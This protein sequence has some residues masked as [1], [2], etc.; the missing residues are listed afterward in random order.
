MGL[1]LVAITTGYL[2]WFY[3]FGWFTGSILGGLATPAEAAAMGALGG[4]VLDRLATI[5]KS[6]HTRDI[7]SALETTRYEIS[8][9][10]TLIGTKC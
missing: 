6:L 1:T 4:I 8:S 7:R 2:S 5:H 10:Y 3:N 9:G